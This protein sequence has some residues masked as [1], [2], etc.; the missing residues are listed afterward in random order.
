MTKTADIFK[1]GWK[2]KIITTL[3]KKTSNYWYYDI[4]C[5]YLKY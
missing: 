4:K 2:F 5:A 3:I 1:K